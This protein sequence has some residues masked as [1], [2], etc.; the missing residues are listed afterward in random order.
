MSNDKLYN[1]RNYL[2]YKGKLLEEDK[3]LEILSS[4]KYKYP[5]EITTFYKKNNVLFLRNNLSDNNIEFNDYI[6]HKYK[7]Y[8]YLIDFDISRIEY[9]DGYLDVDETNNYYGSMELKELYRILGLNNKNYHELLPK[10]LYNSNNNILA[11]KIIKLLIDKNIS[12]IIYN[13]KNNKLTA[14][15]I[16]K[17]YNNNNYNGNIYYA[18]LF[19]NEQM[20]SNNKE[21]LSEFSN[22]I[23]ELPQNQLYSNKKIKK[24]VL[25]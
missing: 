23:K 7:D 25:K 13:W 1:E 5:D 16:N 24:L 9:N 15:T 8:I 20:L 14:L 19:N 17:G 10:L 18:N 21:L 3:M 11:Y 22:N 2:V 4:N 6:I 12:Y